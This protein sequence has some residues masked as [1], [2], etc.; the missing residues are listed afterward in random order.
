MGMLA[1]NGIDTE[2]CHCDTGDY[3]N[4]YIRKDVAILS[5]HEE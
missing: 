1:T 5:K 4:K 3:T 2:I